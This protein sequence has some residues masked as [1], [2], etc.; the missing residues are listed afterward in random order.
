MAFELQPADKAAIDQ[1]DIRG[2]PSG[3]SLNAHNIQFPPKLTKDGKT[4]NWKESNTASYEPF[5]VYSGSNARS[6]SIEF[7]WVAGGNFTP[8]KIMDA[9]NAVKGYFYTGYLGSGFEN[10]PAVIITKLYGY[11]NEETSWRMTNLD[12]SFS[13]E[14]ILVDGS[15]FHLHTKMTMSLEAATQLGGPSGEALIPVSNLK[16]KPTIGWY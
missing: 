4:S 2:D 7:Q 8:E 15:W 11:I 14:L 12:L 13:E 5:K 3:F 16:L 9:I 10:Y 1:I 6:I